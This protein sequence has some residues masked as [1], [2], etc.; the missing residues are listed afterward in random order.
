M[1]SEIIINNESSIFKSSVHKSQ[2]MHRTSIPE[3][4]QLMLYGK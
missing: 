3:I 2:E 4:N 1:K